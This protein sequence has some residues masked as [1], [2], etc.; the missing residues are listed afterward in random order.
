[1]DP[2]TT[3]ATLKQAIAALERALDIAVTCA[4]GSAGGSVAIAPVLTTLSRLYEQQGE[5]DKALQARR[6]AAAAAAAT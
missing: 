6:R 2:A 5:A 3:L 1:M 4:R